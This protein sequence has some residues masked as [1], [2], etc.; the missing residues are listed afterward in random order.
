MVKKITFFVLILFTISLKAEV[1]VNTINFLESVG[2]NFNGAGPLLV[3]MDSIRN[4]IILANTLSSSVSIIEGQTHEV[5]NIPLTG[6]A[7]QHLKSE[8]MTINQ[9]NGN[10][11]LISRNCFHL[12][13]P[14]KKTSETIQTEKQFESIAVDETTGNVFLAG[15]ECKNLAFYNARTKKFKLKKWLETEEKLINMNATPPPPIRKV[16]ADSDLGQIIAIDGLTSTLYLFDS[17]NGEILAN[18]KLGTTIGTRWHLAGYNCKTHFLYLAVET[19]KRK[20]VEAVKIDVLNGEDVVVQLPG[21]TEGVG[22]NYNPLRDEV[23]IPYDNHPTVHV[24]DFK[25]GGEVA[26]IKVPA[27]GNDASAIDFKNNLLYIASWA[28]GEIDIIDLNKRKLVQRVPGLGI[29]PHMFN[30]AF[31]PNNNEIYFPKGATAVNGTFGSALCVFNPKTKETSKIYTGWS[32]VDLIEMENRN[33]FLVVNSEDQVAEVTADGNVEFK[34][35]PFDYPIG[36]V[37]NPQGNVYVSYGPHQSY[38]PNVYIWGAKNGILTID[39]EDLGFYDRRIPR[40]AHKMVF[41]KKGTL[42]FTQNNWGREE[43]FLGRLYDDVRLF[44]PGKRL[45]LGDKVVRETTQRI[46]KYDEAKNWLYL[47]RIGEQESDPSVFQIVGID[48]QKVIQKFE[49]GLV[50]TDL[51]FNEHEI[52]ISNFGSDNVSIIN[53]DDF[54]VTTLKAKRRPLKLIESGGNIFA[55]N[56]LG[57]T[58]Q[59]ITKNGKSHKIKFEAFP[60]NLFKWKNKVIITSHSATKLYV[61]SFDPVIE[62]Y[63]LLFQFEYPYGD[64]RFDS[65]NVSFY[66]NGQYGD[67]IF[68]ISKAK[69]DK[70]GNLWL[71]DFLSG[72][73]FIFQ[74]T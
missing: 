46:L 15:R 62:K 53:K 56:H 40:Q 28:H 7:Y 1:K 38:W 41:D 4:R 59:E 37:K 74:E 73:L 42:Y 61:I 5:T 35:L 32:P 44:E 67:G 45:K 54:S 52:Y 13:Y 50:A 58:L 39:N 30:I 3:Q 23:Y 64:T 11:Y 72:K 43:Q 2:V 31:N 9:K 24:V 47:V 49:L 16:I 68:D 22:V 57:N 60:D 20:V 18:R 27:F 71:T 14:D 29:L 21:F 63:D 10:I 33:S 19:D 66:V 34:K 51:A 25:N 65:R 12:I 6:R 17:S 48:S 55:I 69:V 8:A 36:M 26:E 70:N